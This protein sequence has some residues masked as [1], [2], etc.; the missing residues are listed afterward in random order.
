MS[1]FAN[2]F[3]RVVNLSAV[4]SIVI[5]FVLLARL[6]LRGAPKVFSYALWSLV[7]I[8]L[9]IPLSIPSPVSAIPRIQTTGEAQINIALPQIEYETPVDRQE[10]LQKLEQAIEENT[11]Y[12]PSTTVIEPADYLALIWVAGML[13]LTLY[14]IASYLTVRKQIRISIP[15][16]DNIYIA[17]DIRSPFVIGLLRPR[18]YLPDHLGQQEQE[19]IILHEQHHIRRCDHW[20]KALA[21]LAL[22]LH[23]FN[24]LVWLAFVLSARDMEM[25]CDE[26]VIRKAGEG[27]RAEYSAS[28]LTLATGKRIIAGTPLAFGEGDTGGRIR[29]LANWKRPAFWVILICLILCV[30]LAV[31]LLTNPMEENEMAEG[32]TWYYGTVVDSAMSV[33]NEGD[34]E[35]RSYITIRFDD[36]KEKLFWLGRDCEK[37]EDI[38]N[39]YVMVR[40]TVEPGTGLDIVTSIRITDPFINEY[41]E[42]AIHDAMLNHHAGKY[43]PGQCQTAHFKLLSREELGVVS[44]TETKTITVYGIVLY[45]EYN[46]NDGVL[47]G[48]GGARVP[49][50]M[51]FSVNDRNEVT[52]TE[53]WE[54]RDGTFYPTD[55]KA[56]FKNQPWPDTSKY[57]AEQ[58]LACYLQ[59]AAYFNVGTET[60]IHSILTDM[61][62]H[63][64]WHD[65]FG[66]LME[67]C[68]ESREMLSALG[69]DTLKYC[70]S[71]FLEGGNDTLYGQIMAFVSS[72]IMEDLGEPP[73]ENW[74]FQRSGQDWFNAFTSRA[75]MLGQNLWTDPDDLKVQYPGSWIYLTMTGLLVEN[76]GWGITLKAENVTPT[77]MTLICTQQ[78]GM[79]EGQFLSGQPFVLQIFENGQWNSLPHDLGEFAWTMEGWMIP[80]NDTVSWQ[81]NWSWLYGELPSGHYRIGKGISLWFAP[82][83]TREAM[84]YAEFVIE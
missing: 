34:R 84:Y 6:F 70:F 9:L 28:L 10:N 20:V 71:R 21:F 45:S 11:A 42:A 26:A 22:T 74:S 41:L 54:P 76:P 59:A 52:L 48:T 4:A 13:L 33:V 49:T 72:E 15:L 69:T 18:I 12:V 5:L 65:G 31:C 32:N 7:L 63:S 55:L 57:L 8:R 39:Q 80:M 3:P 25:S 60:V 68:T 51:S 47:E 38:L 78:G 77:G 29:N 24:P 73:L 67:A 56:K 27:I 2:L 61:V 19:Y 79:P 75:N 53:Y 1:Y 37:P 36:G 16:R 23:W 66:P 83:D 50:V 44:D 30:V 43:Y 81:V 62:G 64:R 17:D 35:G 58:V 14:S 82:G 46:L 40:A